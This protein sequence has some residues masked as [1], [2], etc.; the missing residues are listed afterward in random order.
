MVP[1]G[2]A[3]TLGET[4][5]AAVADAGALGDPDDVGEPADVG[6]PA[7]VLAVLAAVELLDELQADTSK[8]AL[9]STAAAVTCRA[10][11]EFAVNMDSPPLNFP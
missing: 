10:L 2:E 7:G 8:A 5:E 1:V 3:V 4:D 11:R 6:D 9:A